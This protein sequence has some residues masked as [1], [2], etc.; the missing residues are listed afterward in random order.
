MPGNPPLPGNFETPGLC[1][2]LIVNHYRIACG[3][4]ALMYDPLRLYQLGQQYDRPDLDPE[5]ED[6]EPEDSYPA[7]VSLTGLIEAAR[8]DGIG[9]GYNPWGDGEPIDHGMIL[10]RAWRLGTLEEIEETIRFV[11][12]VLVG[13]DWYTDFRDPTYGPLMGIIHTPV[14]GSEQEPI[15]PISRMVMVAYGYERN[16]RRLKCRTTLGSRY[17]RRGDVDLTYFEVVR[18]LRAHR[19]DAWAITMEGMGDGE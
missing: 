11:G 9:E 14:L 5:D 17:G 13:F 3:D 8:I 2:H 12:P 18:Q 19:F 15:A 10:D 7:L 1:L 16:R 6:A 4:V